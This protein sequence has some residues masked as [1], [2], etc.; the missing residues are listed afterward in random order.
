MNK[1]E[2]NQLTTVS[3]VF[4]TRNRQDH[5]PTFLEH[6]YA[7]DYPKNLISII[8]IVND[9]SDDSEQILQNFKKEH[10]CEYNKINIKRYDMGTP[11]YDSNRY[12]YVAPKFI[13]SN[14]I[15]KMISENIT[16]TKVYKNLAKHRNS[17]MHNA[18]TDFIFSIDTDIFC[19]SDTLKKLLEHNLDYVSAH[20][21]NGY[22]VEKLN[23]KRA[24]DY[25]NAMYYDENTK[26]HI[27]YPYETN[28][29]LVECSNTGAIFCISKKAYKSGA[30]F[31]ADKI[32]E[33]FPFCQGLIKRGFTLY[34]DTNIKAAHCMDLELLEAY[35]SG[36][37][38]Y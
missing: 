36:E 26:I 23:G 37:W 31:D 7:L 3:I 16:H 2:N 5:L 17:L 8:T 4:P 15:Q 10:D 19:K 33:D 1:L 30:K 12:S 14:G 20:I 9:S 38:K 27:H 21:C 6:I 25:T 22:V 24:Y 34:C 32:G 29:G 28:S 11:T 18:D 13:Q 35:K